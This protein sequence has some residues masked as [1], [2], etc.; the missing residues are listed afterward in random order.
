MRNRREMNDMSYTFNQMTSGYVYK[1]LSL[2]NVGCGECSVASLAYNLYPE[3]NLHEKVFR[4]AVDCGYVPAGTTRDGI[5]K[6]LR[7]YGLGV[8]MY[9][10]KS[11]FDKLMNKMAETGYG[12]LLMYGIAKGGTSN[13]FTS[14]GHYISFS[15]YRPEDDSFFCRDSANR[16]NGWIKRTELKGCMVAGWAV[17]VPVEP[18]KPIDQKPSVPT[19]VLQKGAKGAKVGYLQECLNAF[20]CDLVVDQSFGK[21][22]ET[23]LMS[24]Q[25]SLGLEPDGSYGKLTYAKFVEKFNK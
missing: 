17:S 9:Q 11:G 20:G 15:S 16:N 2:K 3:K 13:R 6:L 22:T 25:S 4:Y 10:T 12:I 5:T 14:G 24:V 19:P 21:L 1:G 18:L 8:E 7:H 23:A